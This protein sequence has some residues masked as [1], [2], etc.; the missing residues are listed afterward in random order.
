MRRD[1]VRCSVGDDNDGVPLAQAEPPT[2]RSYKRRGTRVTSGQADALARLW[3]AFGVDIDETPLD[4]V[5]L[6]GRCAPLVL[7]IGFGVGEASAEMAY[8]QRGSDLIAVDVH[9]PGLGALLSQIE[10]LGLTNIRVADGDATTLLRCMLPIGSLAEV[11][12]FFPDPWPKAR[13][14][15]RRLVDPTFASLVAK[16]LVPGGRLHVA[17]DWEPYAEQVR[18]VLGAH[19]SYDIVDEVPWRP[20]TRFEQQGL[21]A[22]RPAHDVVAVRR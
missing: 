19:P 21:A 10:L 1:V 12:V 6:F 18:R 2:V 9:T 16:R 4:P 13:H 3:P 7:A 20:R 22:G 17:T 14:W 15:K 11:R 8:A 5:A